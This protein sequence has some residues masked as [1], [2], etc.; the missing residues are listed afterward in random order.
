MIK[1]ISLSI[2]VLIVSQ[3]FAQNKKSTNYDTTRFKLG[4]MTVLIFEDSL[5]NNQPIDTIDASPSEDEAK[6]NSAHWAGLELGI[7]MLLNDQQTTTFNNNPYWQNDPAKSWNFNLNLAEH[8]FKI[9]KHYIGITTGAGFN[10]TQIGFKNNYVLTSTKDSVYAQID[11]V[12][13]YSKNKLRAAYLQVPLL[14]EFCSSP[15]DES[16][17][18]SAGVIGGLRLSSRT[19]RQGD[20]NGKEFEQFSKGTYSLNP[21]KLDAT[22]RMGINNWGIFAS[23][24]LI[25]LF[26]SGKTVAVHPLTF[27]LSTN[28]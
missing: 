27:G 18:L 1:F 28:F 10:F 19:K 24:A 3:G 9:Y 17:Y 6:K 26:E 20:F 7:N 11:T 4:E 2:L 22:V 16:F 23:Y 21:F 14:I 12:F 15:N 25:P 8:K 13:T 5:E